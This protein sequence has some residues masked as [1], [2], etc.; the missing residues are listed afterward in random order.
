MLR[1]GP[2]GLSGRGVG[3]AKAARI[4]AALELGRRALLAELAEE[5]PVLD[6]FEHVVH[7]R[8]PGSPRSNTRKCGCSRSTAST[9]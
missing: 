8:A 5:R 4:A 2:H 1:L 9:A 6:C 3:P 7:W